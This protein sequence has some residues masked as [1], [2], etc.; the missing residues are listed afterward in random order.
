MDIHFG[1]GEFEGLLGADAFLQGA[2]IEGRFAADLRDPK[3]DGPDAAGERFGL[4]AIGVAE[5]RVGAFVRLGLEH[6]MAFDAHRFIDENAQPLGEAVVTLLSQELQD[7][8]QQ[9]RIGV[10]GHVGFGVGCVWL[11]PNRKPA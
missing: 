5:A 1:H 3:G 7:V 2:G 9:F 6:L 8:V 11:H 4:V 10:V